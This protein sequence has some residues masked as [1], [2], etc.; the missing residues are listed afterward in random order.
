MAGKKTFRWTESKSAIACEFGPGEKVPVDGVVVDGATSIDESM[1]TGEPIPV[2]K[3]KG[4][5]VTGGTVNGTGSVVLEAQRVGSETLLAQIVR[6]VSEAQRTRAP[7]QRLADIV[8]AY[9]VFAVIVVAALTFVVWALFGPEPRMAFAIVNAVSVLIIACPCALGLATPM[10]IMVGVGRGATEGILIKNAEALEIL[11]KSNTL[12][13]DKTGTLTEGKPQLSEIINMNSGTDRKEI[14]RLAASIE[15]ASEHPLAASIVAA[16]EK[17]G[18]PL[19]TTVGVSFAH[20][21]RSHRQSGWTFGSA[22]Q[23]QAS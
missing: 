22:G 18:I 2:E 13:V 16:A 23:Y 21:Q 15:R 17:E 14:L 3:S 19:S 4:S 10:S 20:R 7:I 12:V 5:K 11:E 9:F 6:M 1:I 8:S